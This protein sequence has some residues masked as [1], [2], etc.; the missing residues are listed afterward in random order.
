MPIINTNDNID[1]QFSLLSINYSCKYDL[2]YLAKNE[3]IFNL[4]KW[5]IIPICLHMLILCY[6]FIATTVVRT[7]L[8]SPV[9]LMTLKTGLLYEL[10]CQTNADPDLLTF[11]ISSVT[12]NA[13]QQLMQNLTYYISEVEV[14][15][16]TGTDVTVYCNWSI[17]GIIFT[18]SDVI[19]GKLV[20]M[21]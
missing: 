11:T 16:F 14:T 18:G 9:S 2:S 8:V 10:Q 17:N 5:P 13:T 7:A 1:T 12:Y 6:C 19:E 21:G 4:I 3:L 15:E 20:L